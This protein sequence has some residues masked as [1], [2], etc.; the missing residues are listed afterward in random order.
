MPEL[1]ILNS[2]EI[3]EIYKLIEKQWSA[4]IKLDCGFLRNNKN[5]VFIGNASNN[6]V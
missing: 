2:K 5:R 4:K 3:K 1:K 6:E